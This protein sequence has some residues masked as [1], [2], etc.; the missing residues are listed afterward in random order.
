MEASTN[1]QPDP[2][3]HR[4][5]LPQAAAQSQATSLEQHFRKKQTTT[6]KKFLKLQARQKTT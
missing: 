2:W 5:A 6:V 4:P 1:Q 3:E